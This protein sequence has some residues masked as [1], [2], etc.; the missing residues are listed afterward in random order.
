MFRVE[1]GPQQAGSQLPVF[2]APAQPR[3]QLF[4]SMYVSLCNIEQSY[5][6]LTGTISSVGARCS[7]WEGIGIPQDAHLLPFGN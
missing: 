6:L 3:L 7:L 4:L 5:E 1:A 2:R